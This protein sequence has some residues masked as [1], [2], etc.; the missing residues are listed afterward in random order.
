MSML[1]LD[2][3][4]NFHFEDGKMIV[5]RTQDCTAVLEHA[6]NLNLSGQVGSNEMRHAAH[7]PR[8]L[9]ERYCNTKGIDFSE[10]IGNKAH[11]KA[12]LADPDLSGFRIWEGR[13]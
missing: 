3:A 12:M 10:F 4:T 6:K 1:D 11:V 2:V 9:V 13:V 7:F 8:V 5:E